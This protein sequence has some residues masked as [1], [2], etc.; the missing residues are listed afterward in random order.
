MSTA[1]ARRLGGPALIV[2]AFAASA[3]CF[4]NPTKLLA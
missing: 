1:F 3:A 2:A 4:Y